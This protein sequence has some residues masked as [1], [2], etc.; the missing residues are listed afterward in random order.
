MTNTTKNIVAL[1]P[2]RCG[3]KGVKNKNIKLLDGKPLIQYSIEAALNSKKV[4][5]VIVST[6][7]KEIAEIALE[8]GAEIPFIRPAELAKDN[9]PDGPVM[10]HLINWLKENENYQVDVLAYL[11][12]TTPFKTSELIDTCLGKIILSPDASSLRTVNKAEGVYHPYWM[13]K[14]EDGKLKS[15]I[16]GIS[17]KEYFQRQLLPDC[18]RLNGV[19]DI[20]IPKV[21]L[22]DNDIYGERIIPFEI[23]EEIAIDIDTELD[24]KLAMLLL[25]AT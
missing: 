12:P 8:C 14:T 21:I 4:S 16:D 24:F 19:V 15:F 5:R 9:I 11:R 17:I 25:S 3:S 7:D 22:N 20:L 10:K 18:Y 6:D 13:F 2:A 23:A 1:I